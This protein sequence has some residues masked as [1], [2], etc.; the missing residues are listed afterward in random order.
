MTQQLS[1]HQPPQAVASVVQPP[2]PIGNGWTQQ[3]AP[4]PQLLPG[5]A[6]VGGN[7]NSAPMLTLSAYEKMGKTATT[8]MSLRDWP[9]SGMHPLVLAFDAYGADSCVR[10]G[11]HPHVMR[12]KDQPGTLTIDKARYA[13]RTLYTNRDYVMRTYGALIVDCASTCAMAFH[14]DAQTLPKNANNNDTRAPY[15]DSTLYLKEFINKVME[16]GL[17]NIWLAWLMEGGTDS[18]KDEGSGQNKK[19]TR[20]GGPDIMGSKM[21]NFVAG[22]SHHNFLLEKYKVGKNQTDPWGVPHDDE[23]CVRVFHSKPWGLLNA[24]GRYSHLLPDPCP[25]NFGWVLSQITGRGPYARR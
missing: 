6:V 21:R 24:G 15:A 14:S 20:L 1:G 22:K 8:V 18:Q 5:I 2:S 10:L 16:F 13:L 7:D 11:Y 25:A 23:G 12:I 4:T 3:V 9:S 17:P 19:T